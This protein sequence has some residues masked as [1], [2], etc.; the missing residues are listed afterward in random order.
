MEV[1][2]GLNGVGKYKPAIRLAR[3]LSSPQNRAKARAA[4]KGRVHPLG[5]KLVRLIARRS[6]APR[7]QNARAFVSID[8]FMES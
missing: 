2:R 4:M 1:S 7:F 3:S 5:K 6:R 8:V